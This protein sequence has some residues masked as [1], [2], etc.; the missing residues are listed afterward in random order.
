ME[1][2]GTPGA[3]KGTISTTGEDPLKIDEVL[4]SSTGMVVLATLP[5]GA[6]AFVKVSK[7]ADGKLQAGWAPLS[8]LI[9]ATMARSK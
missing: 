5:T 8:T 6:V 2:N 3:Y 4:T 9:P 1:I 7:G